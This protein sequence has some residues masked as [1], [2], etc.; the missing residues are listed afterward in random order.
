M[1]YSAN[2]FVKRFRGYL[3]NVLTRFY[4][5][6]YNKNLKYENLNFIISPDY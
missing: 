1:V 4:L 3:L 5:V 6:Y 2:Y